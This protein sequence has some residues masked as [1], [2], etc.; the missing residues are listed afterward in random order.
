MFTVNV[1]PDMGMYHLLRNQGYDPAYAVAEFIDNALQAHLSQPKTKKP[2]SEPLKID[3]HFY[4]NDFG[5]I[6]LQ[7]SLSIKDNGPGIKTERLADAMKPAKPPPTKGLSE[8]GIGMKAAAV[9]FS[10]T[11]TLSTKP[12]GSDTQFDLKFDLPTLMKEGKDTVQV[13]E[14]SSSDVNGTTIVLEHLRRPIDKNKF[15]VICQDLRELYQRF[16]AGASARLEL[17]AHFNDTPISLKFE[18][19]IR[20]VLEVAIYKKIGGVLYAIGKPHKWIV[21]ISLTYQG[22]QVDGFIYLLERGS[23]TEN[24]G[25]VMFRSERVI[26]GTERKPNLPNSLF[27]TANKYARQ[28]VYGQLFADGLPVT[29]T[30]DA[31][32]IDEDAFATQL[33]SVPG[34]EELLRQADDYR[35]TQYAKPIPRESDI[36]SGKETKPA[37]GAGKATAKNANSAASSVKP[38]PVT[39]AKPTVVPPA[40]LALLQ[41]IRGKT[42]NLALMSIIEETIYQYQFKR[43]VGT[44]LCLRMVVELGVLDRIERSFPVEYPKISSFGIKKVINYMKNHIAVFFDEKVDYRAIKCVNNT[45][46]GTQ[47]DV[48]LLNS[49]AHG[50]YQP[51]FSDLNRFA[52]NLQPLLLWAYAN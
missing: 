18:D 33:R 52:T 29:Y 12:L 47:T 38:K 8:F 9:W 14:K 24:P 20:T 16:T 22:V 17:T 1:S 41:D 3:L 19:E 37:K 2:S 11:W 46:D 6:Q 34:V 5:K 28:R 43:E 49:V 21:P 50:H 48:V 25:L 4:S 30:K 45:V 40:L 36:A 42:S 35:P 7:N 32:E 44:A 26:Q 31:F 39:K 15:D 27:N 23:Y 10:D 51:N 13:K